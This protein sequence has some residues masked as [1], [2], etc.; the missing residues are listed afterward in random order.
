MR[1][2]GYLITPQDAE[3]FRELVAFLGEDVFDQR[4]RDGTVGKS[5]V[6]Q[7]HISQARSVL[8]LL[9]VCDE[10]AALPDA[11]ARVDRP[12]SASHSSMPSSMGIST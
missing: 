8:K 10:R 6:F 1:T 11:L 12:S 5:D 7:R 9:G 3:V 2:T 4:R